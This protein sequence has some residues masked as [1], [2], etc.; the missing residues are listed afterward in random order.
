MTNTRYI[1]VRQNDD[2][3]P[4]DKLRPCKV[5]GKSA[6]VNKRLREKIVLLGIKAMEKFDDYYDSAKYIGSLLSKEETGYWGCHISDEDVAKEERSRVYWW[7]FNN[8]RIT[9]RIGKCRFTVNQQTET[10]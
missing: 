8:N 5:R 10:R 6:M 1:L 4:V 3:E 9:F 7:H 2:G